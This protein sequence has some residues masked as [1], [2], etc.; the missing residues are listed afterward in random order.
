MEAP[1]GEHLLLRRHGSPELALWLPV[2]LAPQTGEPFGLYLH[3]DRSL[4]D[5]IRAAGALARNIRRGSPLRW[6]RFSRAHQ[7]VAML[8]IHDL[9]AAG[10]SLREVAEV[11]LDPLPDEWRSSSERSDLRRLVERGARMVAGRYRIL[12]GTSPLLCRSEG[13]SKAE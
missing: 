11:L 7:Q 8:C 6:A 5:R 2:D 9:A 10:A 13:V 3:P 4:T 12:L 1:G